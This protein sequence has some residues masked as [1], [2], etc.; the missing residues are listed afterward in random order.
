MKTAKLTI[1]SLI[2]VSLLNI[3]AFAE[4]N[5]IDFK[6]QP[7]S[8]CIVNI[9]A[10]AT[11]LPLNDYIIETLLYSPELIKKAAKEAL[12]APF[13]KDIKEYE[14]GIA[15]LE[16]RTIANKDILICKISHTG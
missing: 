14:V 4:P 15:L 2:L 12:D 9:S 8:F 3:V 1:T 6:E 11:V 10:D 7:W 16:K 13:D 5:A